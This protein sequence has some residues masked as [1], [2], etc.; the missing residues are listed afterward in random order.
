MAILALAIG[1]G[2]N[3]GV[4]SVIDALMLRSLP[5]REPERLVSFQDFIPVRPESPAVFE[6][7]RKQSQYLDNAAMYLTMEVNLA[8]TDHPSRVQ[9]A[10]TSWNFFELMGAS[11]RLGRGFVPGEDE[12]GRGGVAVIGYGLWQRMFG[13]EARAVGAKVYLNGAPY[14]VVGVAPPGFD[15][16]SQAEVWTPD[17]FLTFRQ[18]LR[19]PVFWRIA[20]RLSGN[21]SWRQAA[22]AFDAE[23]GRDKNPPN[24]TKPRLISL[25]DELV[26]PLKQPSLIVSAAVLLLLLI[27]CANVANLLLSRTADRVNELAIRSA[28]GASRARLIQ[29]LLTESVVLATLGAA[30]SV[31]FANWAV[32]MAAAFQ[33]SGT[34][35]LGYTLANW[36]VAAYAMG[37]ALLTALLFGAAPATFAGSSLV[38]SNSPRAFTSRLRAIL[39]AVQVG[40]TVVLVAGGA[41]LGSAFT[42][43]MATDNGFVTSNLISLR[44]AAV[45]GSY[46]VR[47]SHAD[48]VYFKEA[49]RRIRAVDGVVSASATRFLPL[50]SSHYW[51]N[52]FRIDGAGRDVMALTLSVAPEFLTTMGSRM[53]AGHDIA[54]SDYLI[55]PDKPEGVVVSESFA[56]QFVDDPR[57]AVGRT[58]THE[59]DVSKIVG[60]VQDLNF[61]GPAKAGPQFQI[62]AAAYPTQFVIRVKGDP[63]AWLPAIKFAVQSVDPRIP[64]YDAMTMDDRLA[65]LMAR[66]RF[67]TLAAA[68]FGTCGLL[69]SI[70][71][72]FGMISYSVTQRTREMGIR[73]ALGTTPAALRLTMLRQ[74][75]VLVALGAVPGV[76]V[77]LF[78]AKWLEE[79]V[80]GATALTSTAC[81]A[82]LVP[83]AAVA[84]VSVWIATNRIS[85]LDPSVALRVE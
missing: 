53:L 69:L 83:I 72:L 84:G 70:V 36:R 31:V 59:K 30:A 76:I 7:W 56:R 51:G 73:M 8:G 79:L 11:T 71:G 50:G 18:V 75:L 41:A 54:D 74:G 61:G 46:E 57:T 28:L 14:S 67:Y 49:L 38:R 23:V 81:F 85:R 47:N 42:K 6:S 80:A 39:V 22:A 37:L 35:S 77:T 16:P 21:L 24:G 20:G 52:N 48:V 13:G 27:A 5:F 10:Q 33:P 65:E 64:V 66:P 4:F 32:R 62:F 19:E 17:V 2:A 45:G 12:P 3:I 40:L 43:L 58:V 1:I 25:R 9:S 26:G 82:S 60:V 29:Q 63:R 15:F 68:M 78:A 55:D 44:V 34:A